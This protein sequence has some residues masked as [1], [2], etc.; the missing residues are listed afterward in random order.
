MLPIVSPKRSPPYVEDNANHALKQA[1]NSHIDNF[2]IFFHIAILFIRYYYLNRRV[3]L[4][5]QKI[6]ES[7]FQDQYLRI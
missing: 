4:R 7:R 5:F 3:Y 2:C 1:Q 6:S